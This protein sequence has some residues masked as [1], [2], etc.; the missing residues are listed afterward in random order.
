MPE[1][2]TVGASI[3]TSG[4]YAL[5]GRQALAGLRAWTEAANAEGGVRSPRLG[6]AVPATLIHYDDGSSPARAAANV[7]RLI[8]V[9]RVHVLIGPYAS[10]LTRAVVPVS[11]R[12]GRLLWNHGGA[13]DDI[14]RQGRRVVGILTPVSR[15]FAGLLEMASGMHPRP[16][17]AAVLYRRGSGFGRLA[18]RGAEARAA[19]AGVSVA[20]LTYSSVRDDLPKLVSKLQRLG[21]DIVLSAGA[22]EDECALA[23]GFVGAGV[24]AKAF[25]L[26]AAAMREFGVALGT[27]AEGFLGPS[28]WEPGAGYAADFG[29]DPREAARRIRAM[30]ASVDYP[31]AQAYAACLIAQRCLEEADVVDDEAL[32][33]AACALDCTT[34][35]GRFK[36]DPRTG[37][38]VGHD[39]MWVQWQGGKKFIV[40]PPTL[41]QAAPANTGASGFPL[42]RAIQASSWRA[43][44]TPQ[45]TSRSC[46]PHGGRRRRS[47]RHRRT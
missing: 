25:A 22:L 46:S 1:P 18:A 12:H 43:G 37:L 11:R 30:G 33:R 45:Q 23:R 6:R 5:Q 40:W 26:T 44:P 3:S 24:T 31:A 21:P 35:F 42:S 10:D 36:I 41:A 7:E 8:R 47:R 2:I 34:F 27:Q 29:P 28:Q 20:A 32:W 39:M 15:Y 9:D 17:K 4:R 16:G 13:S 19:Q 38:Q 14:H